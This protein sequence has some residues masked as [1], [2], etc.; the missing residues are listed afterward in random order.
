MGYLVKRLIAALLTN[1]V[2]SL[3]VS[4]LMNEGKFTFTMYVVVFVYALLPIF[5]IGLPISMIIDLILSR[6]SFKNVLFL[7]FTRIVSY[8]IAGVLAVI[9]LF[10][11]LLINEQAGVGVKELYPFVILGIMGAILLLLFNHIVYDLWK[12]WSDKR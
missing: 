1:I 10:Y 5:V 9:F 7:S 6:N 12:K 8:M 11:S 2:F 4:I 3:F